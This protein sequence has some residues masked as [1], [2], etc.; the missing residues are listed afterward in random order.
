MAAAFFFSA[1]DMAIKFLSGDH[2]LHLVVLIRS[3]VGM[4]ICLFLIMPFSGGWQAI[5]KLM[6]DT[7]VRLKSSSTNRRAMTGYQRSLFGSSSR[8][9]GIWRGGITSLFDCWQ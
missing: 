3:L 4:A 2:A 5:K 6:G 8:G 7:K 9:K 1:N